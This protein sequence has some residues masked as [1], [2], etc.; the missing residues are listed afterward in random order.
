MKPTARLLQAMAIAAAL[1]CASA[2]SLAAKPDGA[3]NGNGNGK[4][5]RQEQV[6]KLR[7][8]G[9]FGDQQRAAAS[10]Y[11]GKRHASGRCPPGLAKK[12]NGCQPPGK[13]RKW[14][15]GQPLPGTVV[16]Y[17]VP[18]EVVVRIGVPPAGHRYVRVANDILLISIGSRMVVDAIEDLIRQ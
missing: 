11:Y 18:Q 1:A 6:E 7:I 8:G 10:E 2:A 16:Y 14:A 12:K 5:P 17:P 9:Y 13:A 3:G 4:K 15:M